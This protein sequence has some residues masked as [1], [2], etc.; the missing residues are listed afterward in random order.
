MPRQSCRQVQEPEWSVPG[1]ILVQPVLLRPEKNMIMQSWNLMQFLCSRILQQVRSPIQE[2][3]NFHRG[4]REDG[5]LSTTEDG[6]LVL[7]QNRQPLKLEVTDVEK[8]QEES[9][10]EDNDSG[11]DD[12]DSTEDDT[13]LPKV[14]VYMFSNPSR[15]IAWG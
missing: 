11:T 9:E 8:L 10:S 14:S 15:L 4:E 13:S 6:K 1:R 7:D 2:T 3:A 5:L 12:T